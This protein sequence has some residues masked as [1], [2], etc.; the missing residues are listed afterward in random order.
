MDRCERQR[1]EMMELQRQNQ[2]LLLEHQGFH[3]KSKMQW[4]NLTFKA[5]QA[6]E[7][8]NKGVARMKHNYGVDY[9]IARGQRFGLD[10][11]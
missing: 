5:K 7:D 4:G 6:V 11:F 1:Q 3:N 9:P 8:V 10:W 2:E